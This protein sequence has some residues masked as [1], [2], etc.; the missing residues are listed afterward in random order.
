[1]V[2]TAPL[3]ATTSG[4]QTSLDLLTAASDPVRWTV[5]RHLQERG[6]SCVCELQERIPV[7]SN[8]LSYRLKVLRE[9][10]LVTARRRG[11]WVDYSLAD[12][13]ADRLLAALPVSP[14]RGPS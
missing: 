9:A 13:A 2:E 8:L 5:L 4:K 14:E 10:D 6:E 7:A 11:R 3:E 12:G 1:V